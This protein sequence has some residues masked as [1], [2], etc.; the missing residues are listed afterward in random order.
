MRPSI[1]I[2]FIIL[3]CIFLSNFLIQTNFCFA[4]AFDSTLSDR[5]NNN[6]TALRTAAGLQDSSDGSATLTKTVATIIKAFLGLLGVIFIIM[7]LLAGFNWM[8]AAGEEEKVNKAKSTIQR[9]IIGLII[10]VAAYA[11]TYFVFTVLPWGGSGS[12]SGSNIISTYP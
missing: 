5:L 4:Q 11:I 9:A 7:M 6:Q 1:K 8:T 3:T 10:I 12:P 2:I